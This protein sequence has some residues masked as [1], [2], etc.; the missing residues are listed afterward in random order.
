MI[1]FY[2]FILSVVTLPL[3]P[4]S[5]PNSQRHPITLPSK[6]H[7]PSLLCSWTKF[8]QNANLRFYTKKTQDERTLLT[9]RLFFAPDDNTIS[10]YIKNYTKTVTPRADDDADADDAISLDDDDH[11]DVMDDCHPA[12][13]VWATFFTTVLFLL[14]TL[15]WM[16]NRVKFYFECMDSSIL[17]TDL[18][19]R[20]LTEIQE[21]QLP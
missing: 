10:W 11:Y 16:V 13:E 2:S 20:L 6:L 18:V 5:P 1:S 17:I 3:L 9:T 4:S 8:S 15:H 7:S 14:L 21:S 12:V 19:D